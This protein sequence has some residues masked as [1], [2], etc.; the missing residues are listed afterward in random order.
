MPNRLAD[1]QSPY[2]LQHKDNPVDWYPWGEA[3]F[4]TARAEDK[5][6]FLS[7]GYSTCHW[8]HVMEEESFEDDEVAELLNETFVCVK[9][10]R[11]ERPDIDTVYMSVCQMMRGQGGWPLTVLLT[12]DKR[13]FY[14]ATYLPKH[15]RM[16]RMGMMELIPKVQELWET[17]RERLLSDAGTITDRLQRAVDESGG[18]AS[19]A[20]GPGALDDAR[21][22]LDS[23]FDRAHGGF[24]SAPKFPAPHNLLFLLREW[25]R[26]GDDR[27]LQIVTETLDAMRLGGV[28]DHVGYGFHRYS[29]DAR[30]LLPHFEKM[31]YDQ[32][33]HVMAYAEAHQ[34]TGGTHYE[35]TARDVLT[36]VLRD[37]QAPEGG[38]YSAED[39]DS[40]TAD[41]E[42]EEGAFY[43]W[44]TDEVRD[45]LEEDLADLMIDVYNLEEQGNYQ[46]EST[47]QR[48]GAN[49][50]HLRAPIP[51]LAAERG[52]DEN[53]LRQRLETARQ[54]LGDARKERPRPGLDD[55]IL[56]D[57][58]GLMIAALAKAARIFGDDAYAEAATGAATFLLDTMQ[59]EDGR[60]LH[61]YRNGDAA[62]RAHLD[63]YAFLTWGLLELYETT[64]DARWLEDAVRLQNEC[65]EHFADE[66][67][68]GFYLTADDGEELIV[69][70]KELYDGAQPSGNSAQMLN[71]MR[72]ARLTGRPEW[73]DVAESLRQ[74]SG[75]QVAQQPSG[76][77]GFLLG[78]QFALSAG[79]EV[80]I[81]GDRDDGATRAMLQT[82][83]GRYLPNTVVLHRP[84]GDAPAIA[85][86]APFTR[87]QRPQDGQATAYVCRN[88]QCDAPVTDPSALA[89]KLATAPTAAAS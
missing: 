78:L 4:E 84:L 5:P 87:A 32:A 47:G 22:Q 18:D 8:C 83:R 74:W 23:R 45:V 58:N 7:I 36:Y 49:I 65:V 62:I 70:Q 59:D 17:N 11:E 67:R 14:A 21:S 89:E 2:L 28:F 60:L 55:K 43:V 9:V 71:L 73:E 48:T 52:I 81:A 50:L 27:P 86:V 69:R 20:P 53:V 54:A 72:L 30:W 12:P 41:G 44:T 63:D 66:D 51:A 1:E 33:L 34:I 85:E 29:T 76:F 42:R 64:F 40:L 26:T 19:T 13:P 6:I 61:R 10:D 82:V 38:F 16:Q 75:R 37:L 57:W 46:E 24:G 15:G 39:A 31:L 80:V 25:H 77:T 88:F 56:T 79:R 68:G 3:A 35:R